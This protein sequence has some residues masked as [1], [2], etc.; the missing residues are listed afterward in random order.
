MK[1]IFLFIAV[2][3]FSCSNN[4]NTGN[5][6]DAMKEAQK[7]KGVYE[8]KIMSMIYKEYSSADRMHLIFVETE[9]GK[10]FDFGTGMDEEKFNGIELLLNDEEDAFGYKANPSYLNKKFIV[11]ALYKPVAVADAETGKNIT[12]TV[13]VIE[14]LKLAN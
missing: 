5:S 12:D 7:A 10:E 2:F 8:S 4:S 6:R 9:T 14:D 3:V 11:K 13:W 1:F